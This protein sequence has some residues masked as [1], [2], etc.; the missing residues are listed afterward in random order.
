MGKVKSQRFPARSSASQWKGNGAPLT[1]GQNADWPRPA[2]R[3]EFSGLSRLGVTRVVIRTRASGIW[4]SIL[5]PVAAA[6]RRSVVTN[7]V[8][9]KVRWARPRR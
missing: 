8:L 6:F 1:K 5:S 4:W 7:P 3:A 9:R 2:L